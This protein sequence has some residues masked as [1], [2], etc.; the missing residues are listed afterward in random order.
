MIAKKKYEEKFNEVDSTYKK[1]LN[2]FDIVRA[3]LEASKETEELQKAEIKQLRQ[4]NKNY[5]ERRQQIVEDNKN[6][7]EENRNMRSEKDMKVL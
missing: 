5:K 7:R 2:G 4:E 3:Q 6:L 1:L